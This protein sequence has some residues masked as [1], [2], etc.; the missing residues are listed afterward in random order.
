MRKQVNVW[1]I[2]KKGGESV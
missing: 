1:Y 2:P